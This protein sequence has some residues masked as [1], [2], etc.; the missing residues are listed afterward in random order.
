MIVFLADGHWGSRAG[1]RLHERLKDAF[2]IRFAENSLAPLF[3][4]GFPSACDL[5]VLH[6]I[7]GTDN[8]QESG[9]P[10]GTEQALLDYLKTGKPLLLLHGSSAAF[11]RWPWWR[12]LA[13]YRW[14]RE[15]DPDGG[16]PSVHPYREHTILPA[17]SR[18][19]L[20]ARLSP[21]VLTEDE[22]YT[23]LEQT[24]P[25]VTLME[26]TIPEG[27]F[28]MA[29]ECLSD[30]GGKVMGFIPGHKPESVDHPDLVRTVRLFM[31]YLLAK[32]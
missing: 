9:L 32:T 29:Y 6:R 12:R 11:W 13:G 22:V 28:P 20:I 4:P 8:E 25:C 21:I 14:V 5:L 24:C 19:P 16:T 31:E 30:W 17:R 3:E 15:D 7:T 27:T 26:T 18:H 23:R 10:E 1:F 2:D